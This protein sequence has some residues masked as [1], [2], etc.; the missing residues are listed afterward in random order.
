MIG[1][2]LLTSYTLGYMSL[3]LMSYSKPRAYTT[4]IFRYHH[5]VRLIAVL[6]DIEVWG[7]TV[8]AC[9]HCLDTFVASGSCMVTRNTSAPRASLAS[10]VSRVGTQD[11]VVG[12]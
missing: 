4:G 7:I 6:S 8:S 1:V 3:V 2:V 9:A 5:G 10:R 11:H 12:W